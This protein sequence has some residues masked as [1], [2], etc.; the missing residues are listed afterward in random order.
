M[1]AGGNGHLFNDEQDMYTSIVCND[2]GHL[3]PN[4]CLFS[5]FYA[6]T[7]EK[8]WTE[9]AVRVKKYLSLTL[10]LNISFS[11]TSNIHARRKAPG[12]CFHIQYIAENNVGAMHVGV[13]L[14]SQS[15]SLM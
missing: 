4:V 2:R 5:E 1:A 15:H 8:L 13:I 6:N 14:L 11:L 9:K 12:T 3:S 7:V 10:S